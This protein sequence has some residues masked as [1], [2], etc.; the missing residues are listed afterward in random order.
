M[1]KEGLPSHFVLDVPGY[2]CGWYHVS[3]VFLRFSSPKRCQQ[4]PAFVGCHQ[5]CYAKRYFLSLLLY[6][7]LVMLVH[8]YLTL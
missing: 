7:F 1:N 8:D 3:R 5:S 4:Q 6:L 2:V